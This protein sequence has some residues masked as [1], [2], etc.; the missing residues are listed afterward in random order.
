MGRTADAKAQFAMYQDLK[1]AEEAAKA[2]AITAGE[3]P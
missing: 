1:R 3:K 2:T